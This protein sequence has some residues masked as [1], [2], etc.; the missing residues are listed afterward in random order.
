MD[1]IE[2]TE[3]GLEEKKEEEEDTAPE[4]TLEEEDEDDEDEDEVPAG[5][6][7]VEEGPADT[8]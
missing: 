8:F 5:Y 4:G 3:D 6:R 1:E 2:D 7:E